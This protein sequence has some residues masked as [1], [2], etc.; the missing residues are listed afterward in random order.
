MENAI[1]IQVPVAITYPA[2]E[3]VLQ[4]Q[5]VGEYIPRATEGTTEA[6][7]A[8]ILD[9]RISGSSTGT[10]DVILRIQL[11]ILRT[12]LKRDKVDL[13]VLAKLGYDNASQQLFVQRFNLD[14][15]TNSSFYNSSLEVLANK[16]A[17]NQI[18]KK[19]RVNLNEIIIKEKKKV[20]GLLE[21]GLELKGLKLTGA[22][23]V[24]GIRNITA[25][26]ENVTLSVELQANLQADIFDLISLMPPK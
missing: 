14:A 16:L 11:R 22:I 18:V 12:V 19:A 5:M 24:A 23:E 10:N 8:K 4:T 1:Q 25:R 20:N 3:G 7:Y 26:E 9:V 21:K 6:P 13:L 15:R 17:Y 2:L